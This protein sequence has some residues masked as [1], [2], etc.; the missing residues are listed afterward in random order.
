MSN[1]RHQPYQTY[2]NYDEYPRK[3][4]EQ[5]RFTMGENYRSNYSSLRQSSNYLTSPRP[6]RRR[7]AQEPCYTENMYSPRRN[8]GPK[9]RHGSENIPDWSA[10]LATEP[11]DDS[12]R[13]QDRNSVRDMDYNRRRISENPRDLEYLD[14]E[15]Y[16]EYNMHKALLPSL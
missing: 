6:S 9:N 4:S 10:R 14:S 16:N 3:L 12:Y 7:S 1:H 5:P 11:P 2:Y 13:W 8:Y 15:R